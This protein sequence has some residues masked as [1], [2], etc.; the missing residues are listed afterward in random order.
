M[1]EGFCSESIITCLN[2]C[3]LLY[4]HRKDKF[5]RDG[6]YWFQATWRSVILDSKQR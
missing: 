4:N 5:L 3:T 2:E 6:W 1:L